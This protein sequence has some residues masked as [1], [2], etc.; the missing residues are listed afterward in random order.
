M[1][2]ALVC[3]Y[4]WDLPGGVQVH[5]RELTGRLRDRGHRA[6]VLTPATG[7]VTEAGVTV[8][9]RALRVRYQG[10]VA[11]IAPWPGVW[12]RVR[13][14]LRSFRPDVVHVHE[15]LVPSAA[16]AAT[17]TAPAPVVA[18]FHAHAERSTLFDVAAPALRPVWRRLTVRVA[19]SRTAASFVSSRMGAEEVRLI[20]NGVDVARFERAAPATDLPPGRRILW[21]NRLDPQKGFPVAV[22]AFARLAREM[23]DAVLVVAGDGRDRRAVDRLPPEVRER[24]VMLGTVSRG[25]LPAYH[26]AAEAFVSAAVGQESFGLVLVEAMAAGVPVVATDIPGYR[27][28]VRDGV[29]GLLAPPG[30]ATAMAASLHRVLAEPELSKRLAEAGRDS[31]RRYDWDHVVG[32][33]EGVYGEAAGGP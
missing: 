5:V 21:V 10:T 18:T 9:G 19:V 1:R 20:P 28:V 27:D 24:V 23:P 15:P 33:L 31:A 6:A 16:M 22:R 12:A 25:D 7:A 4:A 2:I 8:V 3:P 17:L 32:E 30:D 13:S 29:D 11:P 26:A 14:S